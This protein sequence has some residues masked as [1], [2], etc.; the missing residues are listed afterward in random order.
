MIR[1]ISILFIVAFAFSAEVH[2][3]SWEDWHGDV[4][5][6]WNVAGNWE[7]NTLPSGTER[8]RID[9]D[10]YVGAGN[11]PVI[12]SNSSFNTDNIRVEDGGVLTVGADLTAT[13]DV[14]VRNGGV[15]NITDG[16]FILTGANDFV[17]ED[18]GSSVT[19]SGGTMTLAQDLYINGDGNGV[20]ARP[21]FTVSGGTV[22][23]SRDVNFDESGTDAPLLI[24][25]SGSITVGRNLAN[26]GG[27]VSI[28]ISGTGTLT[29][30][31][32]LNMTGS[33]DSMEVTGGTFHMDGGII[34][35]DGWFSMSGGTYEVDGNTDLDGSGS[36]QFHNVTINNGDDLDQFNAGSIGI[37]GD[38]NSQGTFNDRAADQVFNGS[39]G[40]TINANTSIQFYD[41]TI[42]NTSVAG[43]TIDDDVTIDNS[44]TFTDGEVHTTSTKSLTFNNGSSVSGASDASFVDG[45]VT[46]IGTGA[47][48][49]P[50]GDSSQ[51][52]PLEISDP[53][54]ATD[55]FTAQYFEVNPGLT[56][57]W[58]AVD[59]GLDHVSTEE[60]WELTE[61]NGNSVISVTLA[62]DANSDGVDNLSDLRVARWNGSMWTDRG[63]VATTGNTTAGTVRSDTIGSFSPF[64]LGSATSNNPL[65][66]RLES[67][68]AV[69]MSTSHNVELR[70]KTQT[71]T[72]NK[73]FVVERS[74]DLV[75]YEEIMEVPTQARFGSSKHPLAYIEVD[76]RPRFG[77]NYYRLK[78]EDRDGTVE[79]HHV[80]G[81]YVPDVETETPGEL[82]SV[83]GNPYPN[84]TSGLVSVLVGE[85]ASNRLKFELSDQL[86]RVVNSSKYDRRA[87][88]EIVELEYHVAP[89]T[90]FLRC[91]DLEQELTTKVFRLMLE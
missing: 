90:Y 80:T 52:Q 20:D 89:G 12:S 78:Q 26:S 83:F 47:F 25:S 77:W 55:Q 60:Y 88:A 76:K 79:Y 28:R 23:V 81:V 44:M 74:T 36:Y 66:I 18:D 40:Q 69:F 33:S 57:Q 62:W 17:V 54:G 42:N 15:L 19:V 87:G 10:R 91:I 39:A 30:D 86:G 3:F 46:K 41:L 7:G 61:D 34:S 22:D 48:I 73:Q 49:F 72:N 65:P 53:G 64:T 35:N 2:A 6:D 70:W 63:N 84:P 1:I 31:D 5:S 38:W 51:Y 45:P 4:S 37:S 29:L 32:N 24:V 9:P 21:V 16:D 67:F 59:A 11:S 71:E 75:H 43:V 82:T 8:V 85:S 68:D 27:D 56:Y 58:N 14:Q 13:D 50:I